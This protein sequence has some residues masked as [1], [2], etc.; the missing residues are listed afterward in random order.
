MW[1]KETSL[2]RAGKSEHKL[3]VMVLCKRDK[4][5]KWVGNARVARRKRS[6]GLKLRGVVG[7]KVGIG[8]GERK[9]AILIQL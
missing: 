9:A 7:V 4:S 3:P 1:G 6:D 5:K 8:E 2:Y